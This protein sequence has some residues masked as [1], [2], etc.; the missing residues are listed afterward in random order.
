MMTTVEEV[1]DLEE[2][3]RAAEIAPDPEFFKSFLADTVVVNNRPGK[4]RVVDAHKVGVHPKFNRVVTEDLEILGH[5]TNAAVVTC[6][7]RFEGPGWTG[8]LKFM[9]V[10][11]KTDGRWQIIAGSVSP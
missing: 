5:G 3:L 9:R 7:A 2:Q 10:W 1:A 11:L 8:T 4:D 6:K